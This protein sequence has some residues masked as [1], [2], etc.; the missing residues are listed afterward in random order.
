MADYTLSAKGTFDGSQFKSGIESSQSALDGFLQKASDVGKKV[1]AVVKGAVAGIGAIGGAI[2]SMAAQGGMARALNIEQAQTM[3]KGLKL[4]WSDYKDTIDKAVTGTAFSFDAAAMVAANLAASGIAAGKD[5]DDSLRGVVGTAATFGAELGDIGGLFSK[6]AAQGKVSGEIVQQFADRGINVVSILSQSLGKSQ[7]EI[8]KMVSAGKIDFKTFSDAMNASFGDSAQAANETFTGAMANMRAALSRIGAK[9]ADPIRENAIP[10]F[11]AV[12]VSLNSLSA[13]LDPIVEKFSEI[14]KLISE[15][16]TVAFESFSEALESG[17]TILLSLQ[18]AFGDTGGKIAA[19]VAAIAGLGA[20]F[21]ALSTIV[22][23]I[24]GLGG[25]IGMLSGGAASAGIFSGALGALKGAFGAISK[26]FTVFSANMALAGGGFAGFK[27]ALMAIL[28]PM[29]IALVVIGALAAA[30]IYL[31]ATNEEFRNSVIEIAGNI[32]S[33]LIPVF[34]QLISAILP[35]LQKL[36]IAFVPLCEQII[37]AVLKIAEALAPVIAT[38]VT[39]LIPILTLI[40]N[41]VVSVIGRIIEIVVPVIETIV[42][43]IQEN[44]PLIQSII[45]GAMNAIQAII[46]FVWPVVESIITNALNVIQAIIST[47]MALINGD[48]EGAWQGIQSIVQSI[49]YAIGDIIGTIL[50]TVVSIIAT[51]IS[52]VMGFVSDLWTNI[53]TTVGSMWDNVCSAF[54]GGVET[55]VNLVRN[56]PGKIL[57]IFSNIGSF[58][59]DSGKSLIDGFVNGIKGAIEGAINAVGDALGAI[60]NL[61]PFSPAKEGPFSG[62][63]WVLYSGISI[64]DALAEGVDIES[65]SAI[66]SLKQTVGEIHDTL[67]LDASVYSGD[68]FAIPDVVDVSYSIDPVGIDSEWND[69]E[70]LMDEVASLHKDL[71]KIIGSSM[72]KKVSLDADRRSLGRLVME[73]VGSL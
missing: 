42:Q 37:M 61:F 44:M 72:P 16:V 26:T 69:F 8:K 47:V 3:F 19:V 48:W 28:T 40:L 63:G 33:T 14:A 30:F 24:P 4:E 32:L 68:I 35:P 5:M 18:G 49:L 65:S 11:N 60:R 64:M 56:L 9:F 22:S 36:I 62:K 39:N 54:S 27:A 41:T 43:L 66:R 1:E 31:M 67:R 7:E 20:A 73:S 15:K 46:D 70:S 6:V 17:Q 25:V 23:V 29:N 59:Y 71:P 50:G 13:R 38:I 51:F 45:E 53:T 52:N 55:A 34:Q 57:S 58:L 10:V 2:G 21:G 12:R